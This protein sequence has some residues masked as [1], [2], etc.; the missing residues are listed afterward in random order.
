MTH[1]RLDTTI[2]RELSDA[3]HDETGLMPHISSPQDSDSLPYITIG[4]SGGLNVYDFKASLGIT[5][6][7]FDNNGYHAH[8]L[9]NSVADAV[10]E[11]Y[12]TTHLSIMGKP[13]VD[14][15]LDEGDESG[16]YASSLQITVNYLER[17]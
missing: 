11:W 10:T 5:V 6:T 17:S 3:I 12:N 9:A 1:S 13:L 7:A 8:D 2:I 15:I 14:S 16:T 4:R